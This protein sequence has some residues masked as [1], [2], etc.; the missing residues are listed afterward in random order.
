MEPSPAEEVTL[1]LAVRIAFVAIYGINGVSVTPLFKMYT[2]IKQWCIQI[3]SDSIKTFI[4]LQMISV[5][6]KWISFE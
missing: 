1:C 5:S 3:K 2:F 6:N 4:M